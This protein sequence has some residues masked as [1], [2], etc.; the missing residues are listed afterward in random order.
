MELPAQHFVPRLEFK[1]LSL[2]VLQ[3]TTHQTKSGKRSA[4]QHQSRAAIWNTGGAAE[5]IDVRD[6]KELAICGIQWR[7]DGE[8]PS[9]PL[10][11]AYR[12][13]F[14]AEAAAEDEESANNLSRAGEVKR[15]VGLLAASRSR[16][17][18][19]DGDRA[20]EGSCASERC[21]ASLTIYTKAVCR[22][23][24][25]CLSLEEGLDRGRVLVSRL[26]RS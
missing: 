21:S 1:A 14:T 11:R 2:L 26:K 23:G 20:A 13:E 25:T 5:D 10:V 3:V 8:C 6:V 9:K 7:V 12:E 4:E 22:A 15:N 24:K 16:G 18:K 19:V 17:H